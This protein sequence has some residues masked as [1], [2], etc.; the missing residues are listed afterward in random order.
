MGNKSKVSSWDSLNKTCEA[1]CEIEGFGTIK[2]RGVTEGERLKAQQ[3]STNSTF[4]RETKE[5][6]KKLDTE[7]FGYRLIISGWVE[8]P[9]PGGSFAEKKEGLQDIAYAIL[10]KIADKINKLSGASR[11]DIDAAKNF[12]GPV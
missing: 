11:G 5:Y 1:I 10:I 4:N 7:D 8:P 2:L 6:E 3:E 9:I 12:L